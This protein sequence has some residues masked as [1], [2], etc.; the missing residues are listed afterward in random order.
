MFVEVHDMF[1]ELG[2]GHG[3]EDDLV[4]AVL[5]EEVTDF[6]SRRSSHEHSC[7]RGD[8]DLDHLVAVFLTAFLL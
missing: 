4:D 8:H 7:A 2:I 1:R 6:F 5:V 3:L